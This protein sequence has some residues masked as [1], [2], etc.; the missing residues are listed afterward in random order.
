LISGSWVSL[1]RLLVVIFPVF[2]VLGWASRRRELYVLLL[3]IFIGL[4]VLYFVG[5]TSYYFIA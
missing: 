3:A 2:I 5:W 1:S 4:Q